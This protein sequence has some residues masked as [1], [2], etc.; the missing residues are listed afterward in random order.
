MGDKD[1]KWE[2]LLEEFPEDDC[3][4]A[5]VNFRFDTDETPPRHVSKMLFVYWV[6]PKS[7]VK[8]KMVYSFKTNNLKGDCPC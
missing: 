1:F 6:G 3:R 7:K 4:F 8:S 5:I 2:E